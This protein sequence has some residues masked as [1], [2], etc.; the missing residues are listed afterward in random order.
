[1]RSESTSKSWALVSNSFLDHS[2]CVRCVSPGAV[3][4]L[5]NFR[6][7]D[8]PCYRGAFCPWLGGF[9]P[10]HH[11]TRLC[12]LARPLPAGLLRELIAMASQALSCW[13]VHS[14][15]LC[16]PRLASSCCIGYFQN[17]EGIVQHR[18]TRSPQPAVTRAGAPL[19]TAQFRRRLK[20][21]R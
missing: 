2:D 7:T 12:C 20:A 14:H 21:N 18:R 8:R 13:R 15:V 6:C 16:C 4:S 11:H 17:V 19:T 3:G 9:E 10:A 1:M 5:G